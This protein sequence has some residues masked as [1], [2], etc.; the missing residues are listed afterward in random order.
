[1]LCER[2]ES[3]PMVRKHWRKILLS[4]VLLILVA[5]LGLIYWA[6][7]EIAS[8]S[9]REVMDYHR[10]FLSNPAEHGMVIDRFTTSDGTPGLVCTPDPSGKI[11]DR[12]T[13][14]RKQLT[15]KG[16]TLQSAGR[17]IGTIVLVHGRKGRKEDYLSIAERLCAAGFRCVIAD[18]PAHG[19]HPANIA[20]YGVRESDLPAR[21]LDEAA[22]IFTFNPHPAGLLGMS[23]GGSVAM[24]AA[25][26]PGAP[27][28]ALVIISSFDSF[29]AV[30][31]GQ[32]SRHIGSTLGP[33][34]AEGSALVYQWKSGLP[35]SAIQPHLHAATLKIP[36][37]VA[38][39]T[40]DS[41]IPLAFGKR[42]FEA[43][44]AATRKKWIEIPGA[45]HNNVLVTDFP[46]YAEIAGWMLQNVPN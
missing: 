42:L 31:E 45:D 37:L 15:E 18:M 32:A 24:H 10:E 39:G 28:K 23:M 9:R 5:A 16:H 26:L 14:I 29:P 19:D 43:I 4:T 3:N 41:V 44:P 40:E 7:S 20:T 34:W 33:I 27:W 22:R 25:D 6:G 36:T 8:P 35:L 38:H 21:I 11:G 46:I 2:S 13:I 17:I 1:M 12:G 30:I